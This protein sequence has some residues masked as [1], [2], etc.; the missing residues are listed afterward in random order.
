IADRAKQILGI[1]SLVR[2][3]SALCQAAFERAI[4]LHQR[5]AGAHSKGGIREPLTE[6]GELFGLGR[7]DQQNVVVGLE[8]RHSVL[9]AIVANPPDMSEEVEGAG[10]GGS[11]SA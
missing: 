11:Q 7:G 1:G 9:S 6:R 5:V 8:K 3:D 2:V 10:F 4:T